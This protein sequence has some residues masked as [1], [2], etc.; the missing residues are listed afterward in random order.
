[1]IMQKAFSLF[2]NMID[3]AEKEL[4]NYTFNTNIVIDKKADKSVVTECDKRI[5]LKLSQIA[6]EVG[7]Q[8]VSEEGEHALNIVKSGN[9]ITIDP[10][11]GTLGYLD[12]VNYALNNGGIKNFLNKDLGSKSDFCLLLG[13]VENNIPR[14][15]ACYN[16][17][18]KEKILIDG[19][20]KNNLIR[21]NNVRNY[22]GKNVIY[23]DQRQG[24]KLEQELILLPNIKVMKQAALG[25]KSLYTIINPHKNAI[26]LHTVQTSGLWDILPA[27][28]ATKSFGGNVF[29][30]KGELLKLN[31]YIIL[32]G[33]GAIIIKGE[34]FQFVIDKTKENYILH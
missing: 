23:I 13:I 24:G 28:V 18:T 26:T 22:S 31:E 20:N 33:I 30:A 12:Y 19:E 3:L 15:G 10:I 29:D 17:I 34:M 11:D 7:L 14:F 16:F 21:E 2:N 4:F 27:A 5:D 6:K 1:M 25:L 32:P 8:V 9:Y